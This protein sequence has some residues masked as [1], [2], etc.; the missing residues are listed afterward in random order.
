MV[1]GSA[2]LDGSTLTFMRATL[3]CVVRSHNM[4]YASLMIF[5]ISNLMI[6]VFDYDK[7]FQI[8]EGYGQT[9]CTAACTLTVQ[10][11]STPDHVGPPLPCN[12]LKLVD[13]PDMEYFAARGKVTSY[14]ILN[15]TLIL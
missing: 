1:V 14:E 15:L 5:Y 2:P 8:V 11:D 9:E 10:G 4:I 7:C 3:G 12:V 13:V 6:G